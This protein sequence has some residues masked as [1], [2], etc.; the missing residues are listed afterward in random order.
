[1]YNIVKKIFL[2]Y[3]A[4]KKKLEKRGRSLK[5]KYEDKASK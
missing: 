2:A 3:I 5:I 1:M 4:Q